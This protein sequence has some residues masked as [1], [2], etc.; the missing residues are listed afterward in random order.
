MAQNPTTTW[1][2]LDQAREH[3]LDYI[4]RKTDKHAL[5]IED[6]VHVRNFKAGNGSITEPKATLPGK[7][8]AYS[9]ILQAIE[10]RVGTKAL[11]E[12]STQDL[13]EVKDLAMQLLHLTRCSRTKI[14]GFGPS[15]ASALLHAYFPQVLPVLDWRVLSGAGI[16][17]T[18]DSQG[19]VKNI[20]NHYCSL[21]DRFYDEAKTQKKSLRELDK[22]WF[23]A[24]SRP[25]PASR[26]AL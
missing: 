16:K 24:A 5:S 8:P 12:L 2:L 14:K 25:A 10:Q 7:L 15:Y 18:Y 4:G 9:N 17:V 11:V 21:I 3:L 13:T 23:V 19:Q 26:A 6:L 22:R 20:E 1:D